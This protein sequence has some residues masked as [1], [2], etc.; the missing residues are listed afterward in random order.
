MLSPKLAI[1]E[2]IKH[3][4]ASGAV[5]SPMRQPTNAR[6]IAAKKPAKVSLDTYSPLGS[7]LELPSML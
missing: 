1:W 5:I 6:R 4:I 2:A 7:P 3:I